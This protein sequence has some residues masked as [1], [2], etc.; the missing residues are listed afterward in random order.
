MKPKD[1]IKQL[2]LISG[3]SISYSNHAILLNSPSVVGV[4][5]HLCFGVFEINAIVLVNEN[6]SLKLPN[7]EVIADY[8]ANQKVFWDVNQHHDSNSNYPFN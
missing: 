4:S 5:E 8:D 6:V 2:A 1:F 7:K 3:A